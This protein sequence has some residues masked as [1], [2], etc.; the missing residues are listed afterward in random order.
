MAP[1]G[2]RTFTAPRSSRSRLTVAWVATIPSASS[3]C[4]SWAWLEIGLVLEHAQDAVLA[5]GL[6][7]RRHQRAPVRRSTN[8]AR[9]EC[10]RLPAC[11]HTTDCGPSM[12]SAA[13]SSPRCAGRQCM[14]T[15]SGAR[16]LHQRLVDGPAR[17]RAQPLLAFVLLPHR[18]PHVGVD[19]VGASHR[20][21][22]IVDQLDRPA[23]IAGPIHDVRVELVALRRRDDELDARQR[24]RVRERGGDVVA[25]ADVGDAPAF[26]RAEVLAH[27]SSRSASAWHG[28][29]VSDSRLTT[30]T[31]T[32]GVHALERVV[33]EDAGRD[34]RAHRRPSC[35]RRLRPTR[36]C[37]ASTSSSRM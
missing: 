8:S 6:A 3:S 23:E 32:D 2:I 37:R 13:T 11:C 35:G 19:D 22:R 21:V 1:P 18:R 5:L 25:V 17:E 20:V 16:R 15:A 9:A 34:H 36:A 10:M 30:G 4:T 26:D 31:S 7:E 29:A 12:T 28:C 14:K 33:V 27:A 24:G